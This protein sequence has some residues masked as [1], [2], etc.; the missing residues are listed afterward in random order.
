MVQLA[1]YLLLSLLL[2][3]A[4]LYLLLARKNIIGALLGIELLLNAA[5]LNF[6]SYSQFVTHQLD[7]QVMALFIIMIAAAEAAVA[8]AIV[9][10]SFQLKE[11]VHLD[12]FNH[13]RH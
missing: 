2:F 11:T 6:V 8:L 1:T 9:I 12:E 4:G 7:G 10:R 13:L 5:A 3:G